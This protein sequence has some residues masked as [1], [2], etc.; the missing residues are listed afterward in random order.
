MKKVT[1]LA[2]NVIFL[3][4]STRFTLA[5]SGWEV[6]IQEWDLAGF[7][8]YTLY[9]PYSSQVI[10]EVK[11]PQNQLMTI[12]KAK[13]VSA[14]EKNYLGLVYGGTDTRLKGR[15]SDSDWMIE[16]SDLLT[17]YGELNAFGKQKIA[18]VDLGRMILKNETHQTNLFLGWVRQN[19]TNELRDIVYQLSEG[20]DL[21]NQPQPDNGSYLNGE[22]SGLILGINETYKVKPN[23]LLTAELKGS[24]LNAKAYGHWANHIPAWN[25]ENTGNTL[26]YGADVALKYTFNSNI[27][28]ELGYYYNYANF[29]GCNEIL[30]GELIPQLV[31][32]KY[33]RKGLYAGMVLLF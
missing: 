4:F 5:D 8:D 3:L 28:A 21:G 14:T 11:L 22:F 33:E 25:W 18:E 17:D 20:N 19:T 6:S 31:D 10:S 27:R 32:L 26:G 9:Y 30:N 29:S 1:I 7:F 12:L 2:L 16:G 15:G 13:Y 23:L 24:F